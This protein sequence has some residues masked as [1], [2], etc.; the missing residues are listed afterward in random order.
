MLAILSYISRD[1]DDDYADYCHYCRHDAGDDGRADATPARRRDGRQILRFMRMICWRY[2]R[3]FMRGL[4][5]KDVSRRL[6]LDDAAVRMKKL[7]RG[8]SGDGEATRIGI[9]D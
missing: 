6:M 8:A 7:C 2:R 9:F 3:S 5:H 4:L 1:D